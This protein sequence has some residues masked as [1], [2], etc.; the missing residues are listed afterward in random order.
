[1]AQEIIRQS[2]KGRLVFIPWPIKFKQ[3]ETGDY[4]SDITRISK[5]VGWQPKTSIKD[6]IRNIISTQ[7]N[8]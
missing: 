4:I 7:E 2:K 1:M 8:L 5:D 6:G 3:V